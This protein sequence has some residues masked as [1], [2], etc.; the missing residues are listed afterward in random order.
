MNKMKS[1]IWHEEEQKRIA[2]ER[3]QS[4][5]GGQIVGV[6]TG[7]GRQRKRIYR[8]PFTKESRAIGTVKTVKS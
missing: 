6:V 2:K 5:N 7:W 1:T 8:D 3:N 4:P